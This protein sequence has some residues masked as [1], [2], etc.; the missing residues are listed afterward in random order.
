MTKDEFIEIARKMDED[1]KR[2]IKKKS[3]IIGILI[4]CTISLFIALDDV[5]FDT[6][7]LIRPLVAFILLATLFHQLKKAFIPQTT[8]C[9]HCQKGLNLFDTKIVIASRNCC[10]C[11]EQIITN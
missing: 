7:P 2:P 8:P 3:L 6:H 1:T 5:P 4:C 11:G 9:P 10:Y